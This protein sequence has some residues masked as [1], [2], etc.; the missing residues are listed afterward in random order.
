MTSTLIDTNVLVDVLSAAD[1]PSR[2]WSL[3]ALKAARKEG[4]LVFSAVVW[5]E[6]AQPSVAEELF[7]RAFAWLRPT[8]E[9]FPFA[10]AYVAGVA[11][12]AYKSRGGQRER[13]L[14][15]FLI[16]AHAQASGHRLLTRDA[17]RYRT[18][19]PSLEIIAP[20]THP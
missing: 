10:A 15:D 1:M 18:Y 17:T 6:L 9:D 16:G 13:T 7:Q 19:F 11:Y 14:P 8:R 2:G 12:R 20:D 4:T 3:A 5:A